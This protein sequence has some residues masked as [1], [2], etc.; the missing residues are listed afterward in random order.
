[1]RAA[2]L[3]LTVQL[4]SVVVPTVGRRRPPPSE[5]SLAELPLTVQ[6]VS[7]AVPRVVQAAAAA[8]D[9]AELPLTVQLVS[10]VVPT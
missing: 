7:V 6:L 10:V 9:R 5:L 2:E 1:M 8:V 3:P 4:V